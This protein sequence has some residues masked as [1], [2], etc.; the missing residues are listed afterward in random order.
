MLENPF[1]MDCFAVVQI[2]IKKSDSSRGWKGL[3][4]DISGGKSVIFIEQQII[5]LPWCNLSGSTLKFS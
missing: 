2:L 5:S 4:G 3:G 1:L